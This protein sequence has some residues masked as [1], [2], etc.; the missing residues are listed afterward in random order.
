MFIDNRNLSQMSWC[1]SDNPF[2]KSDE[3]RWKS[4]ILNAQPHEWSIGIYDVIERNNFKYN[5]CMAMKE[6]EQWDEHVC[7]C[8]L[9]EEKTNWL[10]Q[11]GRMI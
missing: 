8:D 1:L 7:V 4:L 11:E 3:S 9:E 10:E 6:Y 5:G 2:N